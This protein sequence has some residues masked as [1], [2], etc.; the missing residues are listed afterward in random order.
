MSQGQNLLHSKANLDMGIDFHQTQLPHSYPCLNLITPSFF[1]KT[2]L[3]SVC[4]NGIL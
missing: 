4:M 3:R 1:K 2:V